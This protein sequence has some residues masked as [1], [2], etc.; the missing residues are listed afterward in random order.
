MVN[1]NCARNMG[2]K[3]GVARAGWLSGKTW[4][5]KSNRHTARDRS[6]MFAKDM[7]A[8]IDKLTG[9]SDCAATAYSEDRNVETRRRNKLTLNILESPVLQT[10]VFGPLKS[11]FY[12]A[13]ANSSISFLLII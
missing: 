9:C 11:D 7:P 6:S 2:L 3:R 5:D 10:S 8:V 12:F 13:N 4:Q 1:K